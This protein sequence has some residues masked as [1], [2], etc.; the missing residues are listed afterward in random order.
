MFVSC[1]TNNS[2]KEQ[3][4]VEKPSKQNIV[5]ATLP[6]EDCLPLFLAHDHGMFSKAGLNVELKQFN[7][8]LDI[9]TALIG[10]SVDYA[11]SDLIRTERLKKKG[12]SI[13]YFSSL[14]SYWWFVTNKKARIK[15]LSQLSDKMIAMTR[16]SATDELSQIASE[17]GKLK[18]RC[19][20][21]QI[22][23][24]NLRLQ[25]LL[26][27]E[28]DAM[29][30]PQPQAAIAKSDNH[31]VL[32]SSDTLSAKYG[33]L[34]YRK[35]KN[36]K[37]IDIDKQNIFKKVYQEACDSINKYGEQNY[38]DIFFKYMGL[39]NP[40]IVKTLPKIRHGIKAIEQKDIEKA[41][42]KQ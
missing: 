16:Y 38:Y 32:M 21:I 42:N 34:V 19:Y 11:V 35:N 14:P 40:E 24:I 26:N 7:A 30:L 25:M 3:S 9:D 41:R 31:P 10:G 17:K 36:N 8:A 23:D 18:E 12:V 28:M 20:F 33:A 22:N 27:N 4:G 39:K 1:S 6:T 2:G 29:L 15:T 5:I 13:E 37:Y